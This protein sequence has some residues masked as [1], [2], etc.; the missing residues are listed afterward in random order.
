MA[1]SRL[2]Q[3]TLQN[4]F[5][6]FNQLWDGRSA[7]GS[8]EPISA[9][10]LSA[11]QS[12]VEFNNIPGTYSHLQI[13]ML[14][15]NTS[16]SNGYTARFNSDT[17]N[18]YARH[19][20]LGT[21]STVTAAAFASISSAILS[22]ASISTSNANVFGTSVCD[23]LDYQ[24]TNKYKTIRTFGGFDNNG[25]GSI[26]F[27]SG[28]WMSNSAITTISIIPDAGNFNQYSSFTLYGIK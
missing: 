10:T 24:N 19:Y 6:K 11:A 28:L 8:M 27:L 1:V 12:S 21:G 4:G 20:L 15:R 14:V 9:I 17:G 18:N 2:T 5:E 23:I 22:D 26:N 25:S 3:T 16:T 7:V 13:R